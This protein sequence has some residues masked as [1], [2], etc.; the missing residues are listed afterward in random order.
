MTLEERYNAANEVGVAPGLGTGGTPKSFNAK[1]AGVSGLTTTDQINGSAPGQ[2]WDVAQKGFKA[3][4]PLLQTQFTG[5]GLN[6]ARDTLKVTTTKY[7]PSGR[8]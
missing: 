8:L 1:D 5:A 6:Y 3:Q 4:Q 7:A 2:S